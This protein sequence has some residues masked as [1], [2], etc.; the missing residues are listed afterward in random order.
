[1][2]SK[3]GAPKSID[4]PG[5]D[6]SS[7]DWASVNEHHPTSRT[8]F[9]LKPTHICD[10]LYHRLFITW[11]KPSFLVRD[12]VEIDLMAHFFWYLRGVRVG[13]RP[14]HQMP[15]VCPSGFDM[16]EDTREIGARPGSMG[17]SLDMP[18]LFDPLV[19]KDLFNSQSFSYTSYAG[20]WLAGHGHNQRCCGWPPLGSC[21]NCFNEVPWKLEGFMAHSCEW[22]ERERGMF[23]SALSCPEG[24]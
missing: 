6:Y 8:S 21:F 1:M 19:T 24:E 23:A 4:P 5:D 17:R 2:W 16:L 7:W 9:W 3:I 10:L 12:A 14:P 20:P 22:R 18:G 11:L 15:V 13:D